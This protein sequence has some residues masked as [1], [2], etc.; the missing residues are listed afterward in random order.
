MNKIDMKEKIFDFIYVI[1]M[2]DAVNQKAYNGERK[3]LWDVSKEEI[4]DIRVKLQS[5]IDDILNGNFYAK[6]TQ[7]EYDKKFIE[8]ARIICDEVNKLEKERVNKEEKIKH[9]GNF[10]FGNAQK[11]INMLC[12]YFYFLVYDNPELV[13]Y[14]KFCHCPMDSILLKNVWEK[15]DEWINSLDKDLNEILTSS[16]FQKSWGT[17]EFEEDRQF[18]LRYNCFQKAVQKLV[19]DSNDMKNCIEFDYRGWV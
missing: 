13:K 12:K 1:A 2:K 14:F 6:G 15:K 8:L 5:F 17:E 19:E 7:N 9:V 18:P 11:L 4:K 10:T 3:W 16:F